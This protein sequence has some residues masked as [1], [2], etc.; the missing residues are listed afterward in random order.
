MASQYYTE[1]DVISFFC[2][3]ESALDEI[4]MDGSDD[5]LGF[6]DEI[7]IEDDDGK[8]A[9]WKIVC[10]IYINTACIPIATAVSGLL[11]TSPGPAEEEQQEQQCKKIRST[12]S[13]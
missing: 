2:G 12:E 10:M 11:C 1:N 4:I 7:E 5:D 8:V 6:D 13:V 9:K 3:E